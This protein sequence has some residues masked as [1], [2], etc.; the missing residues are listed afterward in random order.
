[1]NINSKSNIKIIAFILFFSSSLQANTLD[2]TDLNFANNFNKQLDKTTKLRPDLRQQLDHNKSQFI[3]KDII[4]PPQRGDNQLILVDA[5]AKGD[6]KTLLKDLKEMG[7]QSVAVN[8]RLISGFLPIEAISKLDILASL[9]EIKTNRIIHSQGSVLSKGDRA[10]KSDF[11]RQNFN[12][13]GKGITVG[14]M[15]DS[16]NC[17]KG[18]KKDKQTKDLP[19]ELVII[20]DAFECRGATDEGRA[21]MQIVHDIAPDAKLIFF[22]SS[23]GLAKTANGILDLAFKHKADI[24]IDDFKS[25]SA[26]FF[27]E[28]PVSQAV[29][30]VVRAGVVFVTAAGN[31][32]RNSYQSAYNEKIN[33]AFYLNS[34]DFDPSPKVDIYQRLKVPKGVG[35]SLALQWDSPAYSISGAPGTQTDLDIFIFNKSHTKV[36]A[37]STFGNIGRDPTEILQFFNPL[38]SEQ[39]EFDL[40][41]TKASGKSPT[42]FKYIILN[43]IE[44]IIS[45]YQTNSGAVF[46]HANS[47]S[48]I[49]IG[50]ANY[51]DTPSFG[52]ASPLLQSYS[53][54]GGTALV[55][56]FKGNVLRNSVIPKKPDVIAPDNV[57]T[58]FFGGNDTDNDGKP[59]ISGSSAAAPHVAGVVALLLESNTKLQPKDIKQILQKTAIDIVERKHED[60]AKTT[61]ESGFDF[62]SGYGLI[63][64]EAAVN[65]AKSFQPSALL[66]NT[67]SSQIIVNDI[68]QA[69]GGGTITF[70]SLLLL[71]GFRRVVSQYIYKMPVILIK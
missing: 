29:K 56:D 53:S 41:I 33:T 52:Q 8:G 69:S 64:A 58:T 45:E 51:L 40:M 54:A 4:H 28:D 60:G 35:F 13:T 1:M 16:Y 49:T 9:N 38:D 7:L 66:E 67:D 11:V 26:N 19:E 55:L 39:T 22:S 3:K 48:A 44:G 43:S 21:L 10:Q 6:P 65:L 12:V 47:N 20:E 57:N 25:L 37:S 62:D 36:L 42:L 17:L 68:N 70:L 2:I 24:I 71:F 23:N 14:I 32:A 61:L 30:R 46:G 59:N 27:Q 63:D 34:H 18:A 31:S 15:S 50:A 5:I